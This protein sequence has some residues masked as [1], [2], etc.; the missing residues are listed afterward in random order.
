MKLSEIT[1]GMVIRVREK[2]PNS[3][4]GFYLKLSDVFIGSEG[5][6]AISTF[7]EDDMKDFEGYKEWDIVEVYKLKK[8]MEVR[9]ATRLGTFLAN[10]KMLESIWKATE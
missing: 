4:S 3:S 10:D 9:S 2:Y 5:I 1:D 7:N 6:L 8:F